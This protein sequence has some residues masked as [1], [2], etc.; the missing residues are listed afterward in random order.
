MHSNLIKYC[1]EFIDLTEADELLLKNHFHKVSLKKGSYLLE[2]GKVCDFIAYIDSGILRHFHTKDGNE[3]T[4][5]ITLPNSFYTDFISFTNSTPSIYNAQAL[6][7]T[8][9]LVIDRNDILKIYSSDRKFETLGRIMAE[10]TVKR[11][12][13]RAMTLSSDKPEER[14]RKLLIHEPLL[15]QLVPQR[16]LANMIGITPE[17]FSRIRARK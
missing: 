17:S 4:C 14:V 8:E 6:K 13:E 10:I 5:D 16:Y 12:T 2:A 11:A 9:L 15:F 7:K 3:I 1:T